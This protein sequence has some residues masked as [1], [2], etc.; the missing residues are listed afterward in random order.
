MGAIDAEHGASDGTHPAGGEPGGPARTAT[1]ARPT[2]PTV[3]EWP[4]VPGWVAAVQARRPPDGRLLAAV[5][6]TG[7]ATVAAVQFFTPPPVHPAGYSLAAQALDTLFLGGLLA[8]AYGLVLRRNTAG[9]TGIAVAA[10]A[11]LTAI[12]ACPVSGHHTYGLWWGAQLAL[13]AAFVVSS[14]VAA[15]VSRRLPA[16]ARSHG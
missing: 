5:V 10:A 9:F 15:A 3:P 8:G 4:A 7:L 12:V 14:T 11:L 16:P 13:G 2:A 6:L 1:P